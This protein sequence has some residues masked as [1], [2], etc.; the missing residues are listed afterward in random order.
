MRGSHE[1]EE[2]LVFGAE[3]KPVKRVQACLFSVKNID[4]VWFKDTSG[5][6]VGDYNPNMWPLEGPEHTIGP[7]EELIGVYGVRN[8]KKYFSSLGFIVRRTNP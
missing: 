1:R 4:A 8:I 3:A 2:T 7:S 6:I 5:L